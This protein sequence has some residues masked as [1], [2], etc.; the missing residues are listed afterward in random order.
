[1]YLYRRAVQHQACHAPVTSAT[2]YFIFGKSGPATRDQKLYLYSEKDGY[3]L[4][5]LRGGNFKGNNS[6]Y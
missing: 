5:K 2:K 6:Y 3:P 4:V 1:M